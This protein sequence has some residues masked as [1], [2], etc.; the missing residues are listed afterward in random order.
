MTLEQLITKLDAVIEW[1]KR[2]YRQYRWV[3]WE[4]RIIIVLLTLCGVEKLIIF[5]RLGGVL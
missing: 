2:A 3:K 1:Q 4:Y 5:L